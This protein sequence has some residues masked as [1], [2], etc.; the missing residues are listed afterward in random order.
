M[1]LKKTKR[2]LKDCAKRSEK[3]G[4]FGD[5]SEYE[6]KRHTLELLEK[7]VNEMKGFEKQIKYLWQSLDELKEETQKRGLTK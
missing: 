2:M 7:L 6:T 5:A 4:Y 1:E 3:K